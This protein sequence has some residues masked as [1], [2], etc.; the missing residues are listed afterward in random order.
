MIAGKSGGLFSNEV[1]FAPG[2]KPVLTL[3]EQEQTGGEKQV[4]T[5]PIWNNDNAQEAATRCWI[6]GMKSIRNRRRNGQV[7]G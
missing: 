1:T 2:N 5:G 6:N 4:E 3:G 7:T